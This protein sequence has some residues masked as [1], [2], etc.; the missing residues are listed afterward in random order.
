MAL[1]NP[2]YARGLGPRA[3][4]RKAPALG[5]PVPS[6]GE[7][8]L[9]QNGARPSAPE[10]LPGLGRDGARP[11]A[12]EGL[13]RLGRGKARPSAPEGKPPPPLEAANTIRSS[14]GKPTPSLAVREGRRLRSHV[15]AAFGRSQRRHSRWGKATASARAR[16]PPLARCRHRR[17]WNGRVPPGRCRREDRKRELQNL[18]VSVRASPSAFTTDRTAHIASASGRLHCQAA[19]T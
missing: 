11:S 15:A 2:G 1:R 8:G 17:T 5:A 3:R 7:S 4:Q 16:P 6:S 18:R 10:G 9:G 12:P 19:H 14:R 13:P